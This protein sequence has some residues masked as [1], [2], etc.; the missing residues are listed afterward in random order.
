[1]IDPIHH[2][3]GRPSGFTSQLLSNVQTSTKQA[4]TG[5]VALQVYI[6]LRDGHLEEKKS[7]RKH[8]WLSAHDDFT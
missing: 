4:L 5:N 2:G 6:H 8:E 3:I 7:I 1:L